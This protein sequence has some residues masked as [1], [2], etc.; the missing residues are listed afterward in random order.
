MVDP[1]AKSYERIWVTYEMCIALSL[2][3]PDANGNDELI[4]AHLAEAE[5]AF[6][7]DVYTIDTSHDR[8][9]CALT[10]GVVAVDDGSEVARAAR[11]NKIF[12]TDVLKAVYTACVQDGVSTIPS[13]R[14]RI[15]NAV[16]GADDMFAEPPANHDSFW[17]LNR[18]LWGRVL[19]L[20]FDVAMSKSEE[21]RAPFFRA[22]Q[23][24]RIECFAHSFLYD[25]TVGAPFV[26][27]QRGLSTFCCNLPDTIAHLKLVV[28][29]PRL[30]ESLPS[31]K[32][33]QRLR[34][35]NLADS[36]RS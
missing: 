23:A 15:L 18:L 29:A 17:K 6:K 11:Q 21:T 7:F 36:A 16:I 10:D 24:S 3:T 25:G 4:M 9:V 26:S 13:D 27:E 35:L 28:S 22:L 34:V 5:H 8:R 32:H 14:M 30:P 33:L 1:D 19:P 31:Y 2:T 20:C 12:P